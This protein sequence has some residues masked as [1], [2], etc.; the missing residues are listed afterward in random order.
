MTTPQ[1]ASPRSPRTTA[2]VSWIRRLRHGAT[3]RAEAQ[4]ITRYPLRVS[5]VMRWGL[6]LSLF[7]SMLAVILIPLAPI[8]APIVGETESYVSSFFVSTATVLLSIL[9]VL[10]FVQQLAWL[11]TV[12]TLASAAVAREHEGGTWELVV[13]TGIPAARIVWGKGIAIVEWML[14]GMRR[15]LIWR[16]A[17][18]L[19]LA[20][21]LVFFLPAVV[22][23][24]A[25]Y[26]PE[27]ASLGVLILPIAALIA[28]VFP[29]VNVIVATA[30][31][32]LASTFSRAQNG[33]A[34]LS[35]FFMFV[36]TLVTP[37]V[38]LT[39]VSRLLLRLDIDVVVGLPILAF[40][41]LDGGGTLFLG[42]ALW[43]QSQG[44]SAFFLFLFGI[45]LYVL[46]SAGL[47]ALL[48]R[49]AVARAR[50]L[51]GV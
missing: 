1:T 36:W 17:A 20:I 8:L 14:T 2:F 5:T 48:M 13:L 29:I 47:V 18:V 38:V 42:A 41:P 10:L 3:A 32:L 30:I 50:R 15:P 19:W 43:D 44:A 7:G 49:V 34:R 23:L 22:A 33:A 25:R 6:P 4:R 31:S 37:V 46:V 51:G 45:A 35:S 11:N 9:G 27:R 21:A 28:V 39:L 12:S 40:A 24:N 16:V 26:V